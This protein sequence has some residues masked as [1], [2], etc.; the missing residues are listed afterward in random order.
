MRARATAIAVAVSLAIIAVALWRFA[1]DH[2]GGVYDDAFIYLR[3]VKN[4]EAGCGLR[5]NCGDAPVEGFTGP[6]YLALLWLGGLVTHQLIDLSQVIC[7]ASLAAALALAVWAAVVAGRGREPGWLP[8]ALAVSVAAALALDHFVL[9]NAITGMETALAAAAVTAIGVAALTGRR[10]LLI[11]AIGAALLVRPECLVFAA[12]LPLL[13]ALRR[14]RYLAAAAGIVVA[15][16]VARY[17]VF[18][19]LAPN[20][21]YA[22]A[23]GTWR[24]G[25]LG[26][27]YIADAVA[28]FPLAFA[29]PLALLLP[30]GPTRRACAFVLAASAAWVAFFLRTGGDLF[31]YSRLMFPLVPVLYV[32]A[33][34]GIAELARRI[35]RRAPAAAIAAVVVAIA[36]GGRAAAA[37][38]LAPQHA[39][40]RVVE[41]AAIGSYLRAHFPKA[42]VATVPIGAIG[43]YS[44][45][46]IVDLVGLTQP[47]IARAGRSVPP[48]LLTKQWIGHERHC[49]ECVLARAPALIVTTMHRDRPWRDLAEARA[50]FY[51]DWLLLQEIKAGRAPYRVFD[52]EV[53]PGDHILMFERSEA[54]S[55]SSP[56]APSAPAPGRPAD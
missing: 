32:L 40:P 26:L 38:A 14:P 30:A 2:W 17:A 31:E 46:P 13:P 53:M 10:W 35:A 19:A 18:G 24:H 16:C 28:D 12:A 50:G 51:A 4:L 52:A 22:K 47:D 45:L 44:R 1:L 36:A 37:H 20:T 33:L 11:A 41:W 27:A 23:G 48:E 5:F 39:S 29:A 54:T 34:A 25:E 56:A 9:L 49:T 8:A 7:T 43:Y 42:T 3:Y 55:P 15:I 21:Y 6:L